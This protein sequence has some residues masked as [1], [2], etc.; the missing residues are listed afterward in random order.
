M[1]TLCGW[2]VGHLEQHN[3]D[4]EP[5]LR[6]VDLKIQ[7]ITCNASVIRCLPVPVSAKCTTDL[8]IHHVA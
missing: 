4:P 2:P 7:P 5:D 1:W 3:P 6:P 8:N